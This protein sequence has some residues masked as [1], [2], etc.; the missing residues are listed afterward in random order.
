MLF[1][2]LKYFNHIIITHCACVCLRAHMSTQACIN[3]T[4][5]HRDWI[6]C[7]IDCLRLLLSLLP[8]F[9]YTLE[10]RAKGIIRSG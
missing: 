1:I 5:F 6:N 8:V 4:A 2:F 3:G 9:S 7:L 10:A